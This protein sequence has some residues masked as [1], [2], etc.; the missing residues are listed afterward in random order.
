MTVPLVGVDLG[1]DACVGD[2]RG[3]GVFL[4]CAVCTGAGAG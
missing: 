4:S 1:G 2:V 3:K